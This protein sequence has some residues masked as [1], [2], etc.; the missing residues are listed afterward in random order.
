LRNTAL[1]SFTTGKPP[2][3]DE[4]KVK[5]S[6]FVNCAVADLDFVP[7]KNGRDQATRTGFQSADQV[8]ESTAIGDAKVRGHRDLVILMFEP[9][10]KS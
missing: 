6:N 10:R 4:I 9:V 5:V 1:N 2:S 8:H 7:E 3:E